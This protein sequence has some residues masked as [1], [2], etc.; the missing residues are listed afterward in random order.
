MTKLL[1]GFLLAFGLVGPVSAQDQPPD[2]EFHRKLEEL[3]LR[4]NTPL[5]KVL[6][7]DSVRF[8][9]SE[10]KTIDGQPV[11]IAYYKV[12]VTVL[13][14]VCVMISSNNGWT[15]TTNGMFCENGRPLMPVGASTVYT[16][17]ATWK[18]TEQGWRLSGK[19]SLFRAAADE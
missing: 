12:L 9:Y 18:M 16:L 14:P 7:V 3:L 11:R 4:A 1:C 19:A 2:Y 8:D 17:P 10:Q 15:F 13:V 6:R 5:T